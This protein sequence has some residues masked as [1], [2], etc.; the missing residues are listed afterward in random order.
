MTNY[1]NIYFQKPNKP[2]IIAG[3]VLLAL[4]IGFLIASVGFLGEIF[5]LFIP[6]A[7]AVISI[8]YFNPRMGIIFSLLLAFMVNGMA[9]YVDIPFGLAIDGILL[10]TLFIIFIFQW[11]EAEWKL[12]NTWITWLMVIWMVYTI[13]EL[14]NP[15]A[16][17]KIAWF[18]A[19]RGVALYP[20]LV[21]IISLMVFNRMRD[22]EVFL[23]IWM[24]FSILATLKAIQ[25]IYF[26]PDPWEKQ[27]LNTTGGITHIIHGRLRAFSF[28]SDAGQ[29]GEA[30]AHVFLVGSILAFNPALAVKKRYFYASAAFMGL[31]GVLLSGTRSAF[32][33]PATGF[34][35]F[36][37]LRKNF[38]VFIVGAIFGALTFGFLKYT[39]IGNGVYQIAR[40]RTALNPKDPSLR[41]RI[42]NQK[43]LR[44]YLVDRP[45]GGGIG[46][47]GN[48]GLRF[49]PHSFLAQTP[50]DSW[51]VRIWAEMGIVGL[52][53]HI[54]ILSTIFFKS[55][56][57]IWKKLTKPEVIY[58]MLAL[59]SGFFGIMVASYANQILGQVPTG[60]VLY[61]SWAFLI[62]APKFEAQGGEE[63]L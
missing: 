9:R 10:L 8:I 53:L 29:F 31:I 55:F 34:L 47:A 13:L 50:T 49:S 25:Q 21:I 23:K 6:F 33:I 48:W 45:F 19:M 1:K 62:L 27:W 58:P 3:F 7:L 46:S 32:F 63:K 52:I 61:L 37:F 15:E 39:T 56:L 30:Q 24:I 41:V 54:L 2:L 36:L 40:M 22:L 59:I 35:V 18:Y 26:G 14:F 17:S 51:Y 44:T 57:M 38:K 43:K 5:L 20:L 12:A 42:E 11:K 16:Q 4:M 60:I 28:Y